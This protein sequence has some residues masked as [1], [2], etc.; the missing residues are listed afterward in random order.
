VSGRAA[1]DWLLARVWEARCA[2]CGRPLDAPTK[3]SVCEHCWQ[4]VALLAAPQCARCGMALRRFPD[5][6]FDAAC[7][8]VD[9]PD[10]VPRLPTPPLCGPCGV[11]EPG[12]LARLRAAGEYA[13]ALRRIIHAFKYD[14]HR[15]L[16]RPLGRLLRA[17]ARDVLDGV[18]LIVAVPLHATK[19]WHRGFNQAGE[20]ARELPVR[21]L[22]ALAR[23]RATA[24]QAGRSAPER[25]RN[26][27]GAFAPSRRLWVG[28]HVN[29]PPACRV[30]PHRLRSWIAG[31]WSVAGKVVLLVDDVRTTG[32]TLEECATVL[33]ACGAREVRAVTIAVVAVSHE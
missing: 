13:G 14:G 9:A 5:A 11:H 31:R 6:P 32:A 10:P 18:D 8:T 29:A 17:A 16:G 2:S 28:A 1:V 30:L 15:S 24:P 33:I 21:R 20:L 7:V 4:S 19:A 25:A 26:V 3:G 12:P 27:R 23:R 22:H